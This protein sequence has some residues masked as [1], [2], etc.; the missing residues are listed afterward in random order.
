MHFLKSL[1]ILGVPKRFL[2][3]CGVTFC[4][5]LCFRS[6]IW[7]IFIFWGLFFWQYLSCRKVFEQLYLSWHFSFRFYVFTLNISVLLDQDCSLTEYILII[8]PPFCFNEDELNLAIP[9]ILERVENE[10]NNSIMI[11]H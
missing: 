10:A 6:K 7:K 1:L 4:Y 2:L 11:F 9:W 3:K 8:K 5:I